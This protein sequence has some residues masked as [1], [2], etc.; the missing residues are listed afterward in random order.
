MLWHPKEVLSKPSLRQEM[1]KSLCKATLCR[2]EGANLDRQ[3]RAS[4]H[5]WIYLK[6]FL[7]CI[8]RISH[9]AVQG[10]CTGKQYLAEGC[11][12]ATASPKHRN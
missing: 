2:A 1:L 4:V 9:W 3:P 7:H 12:Q 6:I 8:S 5:T 10:I 11:H